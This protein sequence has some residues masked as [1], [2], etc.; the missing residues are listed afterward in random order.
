M[1]NFLTIPEEIL[2][3]SID[4]SGGIS[5]ESKTLDVV[6]ASAILM[7]LAI[8]KR[9]DT[10]LHNLIHIDGS[11]TGDAI[12]DDALT[13]L[14]ENP[15]EKPTEYWVTQLG[16][17]ADV[18]KE[19]LLASLTLKKVL[20][21]ENKRILWMFSSRK[22]PIIGDKELKEVK[23]RVRELV[24]SSEI[25]D[26]QEM[27]IVSLAFYG[28]LLGFLFTANEID[29]YKAR[30]EQ[31]AKMDLIGQSIGKALLEFSVSFQFASKAKAI[32]GIKTAEQKLEGLVDDIKT[33]YRIKNDE[34][35]PDWLRRGTEQ[36]GKTLD[37]IDK[38]G[39]SDIYYHIGKKEY[40][41]RD[42]ASVFSS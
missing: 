37:F 8:R 32:L 16:L 20:K 13:F 35:L 29:N 19:D 36:Y 3:L 38:V 34:D 15:V 18:Y 9:I 10:D 23:T 1:S 11:P 27:A 24:F 33:K 21:V 31:I 25:P 7:D 5:P 39:T 2:L 6:L 12:L 28:S 17:R 30:I 40:F 4:E 14:F 41:V 26:L 42:Y 22:Y